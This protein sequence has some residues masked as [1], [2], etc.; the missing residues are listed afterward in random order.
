MEKNQLK[1]QG[2]RFGRSLQVVIKMANIYSLDHQSLTRPIQTS[3]DILNALVKQTRYLTIGFVEQRMIVN[4]ILTTEDSIKPLENEFLRRGI[5]AVT[6]D[7]GITLAAY[8]NAIDVLA[9]P[10][11][12]IAQQGGIMA[13][14]E[15]RTL[16]FVRIFP[17]ENEIRNGNGDTVLDVSSEEYLIAR[18][19]GGLNTGMPQSLDAMLNQM[20]PAAGMG[21]PGLGVA[22]TDSGKGGGNG[23]GSGTGGSVSDGPGVVGS[24]PG[25]YGSGGPGLGSSGFGGSGNGAPGAAGPGGP[26]GSSSSGSSASTGYLGDLQRVVEQRL[27]ASLK[28]P[29]E[30]PQK[31]YAEMTRLI[32]EMRQV[33]L[34]GSAGQP[35]DGKSDEMTTEV[36]ENAALRWAVQRL[37]ATPSGEEGYLVEEQVFRVL[38][39]SLQ[40][41]QAAARMA[42]KLA[43]MVKEY[44]MPRQTCDRIH[45]ELRWAGLTSKQKLRELLCLSHFTRDEFRRLL[46]LI[47]ELIR[48]GRQE[49]AAAL[50]LQYFSIFEN[51]GEIRIEEIGR[52]PELLQALAGVQGEFWP[53]AAHFLT[54]ALASARLNQVMHFQVV[55]ALAALT[56]TAGRYEDFDLVCQVGAALEA[57]AKSGP[58]HSKCCAAALSNLLTP[59][60]VDRIAEIFLRKKDDSNWIR[61]A[62][63]LLRWSG[64]TAV[65]RLFSTLEAEPVAAN[66]LA[67]I[68]LLS[69]VGSI[70]LDAARKRIH[71]S[72][73]YVVRNACKILS[74]LK[75][76][77]LFQHIAHA[78]QHKDERVQK[79]A[80]QAV[81]ESRMAGS[82]E[83]LAHAL[84][85]LPR[86]LQEEALTELAFQHEKDILPALVTFLKSPAAPG[87]RIL[88]VVIQI[89]SAIPGDESA[90]TLAAVATAHPEF[91]PAIR[92][93]AF[94]A[95]AR[96][97]S[98]HAQM[99]ARK[100]HYENGNQLPVQGTAKASA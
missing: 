89:I 53:S 56:Q 92:T 88:G 91:S 12:A 96:K 61:M 35:A 47:R 70:G 52:M 84:P 20:Q 33:S 3:Y 71:H 28:N 26:G 45:E 13:F 54:E 19:L 37:S 42:A 41:T 90:E 76:P 80:L 95:L 25:G 22:D 69:R 77:E 34:P 62:A 94:Q 16:E 93:A 63:A 81:K 31:A 60:V 27:E 39:R 14:L 10:H 100:L 4:N 72:E 68:R 83:A 17:A 7:A 9:A 30:D 74:E 55:N 6:F 85:F 21:G 44:A 73:W 40:T 79:A 99:L 32:R 5:G 59:S 65:E 36:F 43:E 8:R 97:N 29:D 23:S 24:G 50:G 87:D 51:Y 11:T 57:R 18:A 2:I 49:D 46:D 78:F 82:G 58:G 86:S 98:E 15:S 75:D 48:H 64:P 66:R 67:L 1:T 38:L